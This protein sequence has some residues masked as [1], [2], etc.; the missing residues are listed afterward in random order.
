M[1][2]RQVQNSKVVKT[3]TLVSLI[4]EVSKISLNSKKQD[5]GT[6][7]PK[8]LQNQ[9]EKIERLISMHIKFSIILKS[10]RSCYESLKKK[11]SSK[12]WLSVWKNKQYLKKKKFLNL[13]A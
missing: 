4:N 3:C 7:P 5:G 10:F 11:L 13:K 6:K 9:P 8:S 1:H 12:C 2:I